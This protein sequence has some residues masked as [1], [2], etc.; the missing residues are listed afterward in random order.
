MS[1]G[2]SKGNFEAVTKQKASSHD[3][4]AIPKENHPKPIW[5]TGMASIH[6]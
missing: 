4:Q 1:P 6:T 5:T 3:C 2:V